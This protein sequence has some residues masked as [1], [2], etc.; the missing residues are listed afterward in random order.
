MI[1]NW[2]VLNLNLNA[3]CALDG[4][5]VADGDRLV[6]AADVVLVHVEPGHG[7]VQTR[8]VGYIKSIRMII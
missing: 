6:A 4:E 3:F 1:Q 7:H 8:Y 5:R 2:K